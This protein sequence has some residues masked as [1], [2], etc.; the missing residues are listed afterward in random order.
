MMSRADIP[1]AIAC[2]DLWNPGTLT[3]VKRDT[4]RR[5]VEGGLIRIRRVVYHR[6]TG[7]V[8]V[9]YWSRLPHAWTLQQLR[10]YTLLDQ[11]EQLRMD[12]KGEHH[13]L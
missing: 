7:Y 13:G 6:P 3:A 12:T 5:A 10:E 8:T 2:C 4:Y 9:E 11:G 1:P